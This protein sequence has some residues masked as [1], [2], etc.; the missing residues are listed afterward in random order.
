MHL[1]CTG[2]EQHAHDLARRVA[3]DDRVVHRDDPLPG[4][5]GDGVVLELDP[6]PPEL[7]VGLDEGAL[8][9]PVLDQPF[10]ER[11]PERPREAD[12]GRR[13]RVRNRQDEIGLDRRFLREPF[14]HPH[15]RVVHLDPLETAVGPREVEELPDAE[16]SLVGRLE[17]L[18]RP[19]TPCVGDDELARRDLAHEFGAHEV[20]RARLGRED[21]VLL[22]AADH[23]R[24]EAVRVAE[25]DQPSLRERDDGIGALEPTHRVRHGLLEGSGVVCDQCGDQLAVG[26]RAEWDAVLAEPVPQLADVDQV[27]VV[28]QCH[29]ACPAVL[30]ERLRV[31]PLRRAGRRVARVADRD[32]AAKAA[33]LLLVEDLG[34]EPEVAQ[35]RQPPVLGDGDARRLLP[36]VL[37]RE[38]AEVRQPRHVTVGGV[39]AEDAAHR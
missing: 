33:E 23:E 15:P 14:A 6:L 24:P 25:P 31:R 5:L 19:Q 36:A 35:R 38:Q 16:R 28:A 2:V 34:D 29:R 12:R 8:D 26:R 22:Q 4:D 11:Q 1:G 21:K 39:D 3:A 10:T 20:E 27:A 7:L 17:R 32:L 18:R 30:H 9:V 13:A 37:Q